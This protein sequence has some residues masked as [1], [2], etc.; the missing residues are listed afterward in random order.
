MK[1]FI[2]V[3]IALEA[4]TFLLASAL[5]SGI[6]IPILSSSLQEP[7]IIPATI[8]EGLI[9]LFL[10]VGA[11]AVFAGKNWSLSLAIT[12]HAVAIAGVLIGIAALALGRGPTTEA[13]YIYHRVI[14]IVLVAGLV[15]LL[16]PIAKSALA[17]IQ[18]L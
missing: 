1:N 13:N 7:R 15:L 4:S 16:I 10:A 8:A 2:L 18:K 9:G 17:R 5:H 14:L 6:E 11:Y 12:A 3:F